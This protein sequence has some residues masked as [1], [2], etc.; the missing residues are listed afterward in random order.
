MPRSQKPSF[1]RPQLHAIARLFDTL[2]D[3]TRLL[4]LHAL[5]ES[6]SCV[7][8]VVTHTGCKQANVSKQ[9]GLLFDAGLVARQRE[10][11]QVCY[12]IQE[13][14]IFELCNLVCR[15]LQRDSARQAEMFRRVPT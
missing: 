14:L 13:P 9:L 3:P 1:D 5:K 15:K 8:D 12:S 6:P 4:I 11:N 2:S 7:S 10:G